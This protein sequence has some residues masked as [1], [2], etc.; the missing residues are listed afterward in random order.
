MD[1]STNLKTFT[2]EEF[3]KVAADEPRSSGD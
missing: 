2:N 3:T 1:K